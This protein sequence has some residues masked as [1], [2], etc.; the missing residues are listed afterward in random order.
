MFEK[1]GA[2]LLSLFASSILGVLSVMLSA[3]PAKIINEAK[4][5]L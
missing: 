3:Q 1:V 4:S 2:T 5:K